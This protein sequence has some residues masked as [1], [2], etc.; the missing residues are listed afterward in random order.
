MLNCLAKADSTSKEDVDHSRNNGFCIHTREPL[1]DQDITAAAFARSLVER[2]RRYMRSICNDFVGGPKNCDVM[3]SYGDGSTTRMM[4]RHNDHKKEYAIKGE[5]LLYCQ[6][7]EQS[8][9]FSIIFP[10]GELFQILHI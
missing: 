1:V 6:L 3:L 9:F 10:E 4:V 7:Y 2:G 5:L 8:G